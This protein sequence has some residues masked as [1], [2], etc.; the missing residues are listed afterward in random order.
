MM[1][2]RNN[3]NVF[4]MHSNDRIWI[5]TFEFVFFRDQFFRSLIIFRRKKIQKNWIEKWSHFVYVIF[6]NGW[7]DNDVELIWLKNIFHSETKHFENCR[8]LIIDEHKSHVSTK[9]I[10]FCWAI[11]IVFFDLSSHT[12]HYLQ[13]FDV[14]C[15]SPLITTYQRQLTTKNRTNVVQII[16]L[17]FLTCF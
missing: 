9:F 15:F 4:S 10:E 13:S 5:T 2:C 7:I 3:K 12:I 11:N 6:D 16:K 17:N 8:L 1:I 14:S